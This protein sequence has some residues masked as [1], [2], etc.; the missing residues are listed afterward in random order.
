MSISGIRGNIYVH[1]WCNKQYKAIYAL[2][3][4]MSNAY[5]FESADM[6]IEVVMTLPIA[7]VCLQQCSDWY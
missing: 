6:C 3:R 5:K 2:G 4:S 1:T 7:T